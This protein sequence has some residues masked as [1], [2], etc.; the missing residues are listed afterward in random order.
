LWG[1]DVIGFLKRTLLLVACLIGIQGVAFAQATSAVQPAAPPVLVQAVPS[2]DS[3]YVLAAED[4]ID[5]KVL[6]Q[7]EFQ[8]G[9]R[10]EA[11]GTVNI[12]FI[13]STMVNGQTPLTLS[14]IIADKL[15]SGGY[16]TKPIVTVTVV[17]FA[18]R[19]VTVLGEV[20]QP[21]LLPINRSYRVSEI[22]ARVGGI[23]PTGT[24]Q[25]ILR[26]ATGQELKLDF[27]KLATGM[28]DQDPI[29]LAGDK[30]YVP[31]AEIY[32][33]Y[34]QVNQP[35]AF[36]IQSEMTLR[37]ALARAGGMTALGSDKRVQVFRNGKP[38]RADLER[39]IA[40]GDVVVVGERLF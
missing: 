37:K 12:Q 34:G 18:S 25:V 29:V 28:G 35:G 13:G 2:Q 7:P 24:D 21:G 23:R 14:R 22:I 31:A 10:V 20:A 32:Y 36:P 17:S 26:R 3:G 38:E 39:P 5:V 40:P 19:Y 33:I 15:R 16:Y 27:K 11:D 9:G 8:A 30:L 6:G 4:V 1:N